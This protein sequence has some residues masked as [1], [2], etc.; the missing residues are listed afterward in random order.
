MSK[1]YPLNNNSLRAFSEQ[2]QATAQQVRL[3]N[4][5]ILPIEVI[6]FGK[7]SDALTDS[8]DASIWLEAYDR[9]ALPSY[10]EVSVP[11]ASNFVFF[12][13]PGS[14]FKMALSGSFASAK[15]FLP[16][17]AFWSVLRY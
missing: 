14:G 12:R 7:Q 5:H 10:Q 6:G 15:K 16:S 3:A 13:L 8:L 9:K 2:R 4:Y 17:L 1:L 11:L